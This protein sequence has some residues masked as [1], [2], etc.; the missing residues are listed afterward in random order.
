MSETPVVAKRR[1]SWGRLLLVAS[2]AL[3]LLVG[4]AI[5]AR[6][7]FPDRVG[8]MEGLSFAQL[9]PRRFFGDLSRERR[10]ELLDVLKTYR[11]RFKSGRDRMEQASL[12]IADALEAEPYDPAATQAA[13]NGFAAIGGT[14]INDG[15]KVAMDVL[16]KLS[17]EER[18]LLAQRLRERGHGRKR[19]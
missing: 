8:R 11:D 12:V 4:G 7:A 17:P 13:V 2:L 6:F 15:A 19:K 14:L 3:N 18:K 16:A 5:A 1:W 10:K 9:L